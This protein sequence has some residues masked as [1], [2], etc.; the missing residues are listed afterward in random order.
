MLYRCVIINAPSFFSMCWTLVKRVLDKNT[1]KKIV[2]FSS[3]EKAKKY[4]LKLID[5]KEL[6]SD[7]GGSNISTDK[8]ILKQGKDRESVKS[9]FC[10]LL[11]FSKR[12]KNISHTFTITRSETVDVT[13]YTRCQ[14]PLHFEILDEKNDI[15]QTIPVDFSRENGKESSV[16]GGHSP[17]RKHSNKAKQKTA[18][19]G[20]EAYS[21]QLVV[22]FDK[23]GTFTLT[24]LIEHSV[25][26][27]SHHD[28]YLLLV[29]DIRSK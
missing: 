24:G 12:H 2:V 13:I 4:L 27:N 23:P 1:A 17:S 7:Y 10:E 21:K 11:H 26:H 14:H 16:N 9:Q 15:I 3:E 5:E 25:H 29:G 20:D 8:A 22:A 19:K 6:A 18:D 28:D